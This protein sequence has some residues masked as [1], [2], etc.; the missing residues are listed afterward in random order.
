MDDGIL[1]TLQGIERLFYDMFAGLGEDLDRHIVRNHVMIH[2]V[3]E[4]F[5]FGLGSGGEAHFDFL[6]A[7]G[8]EDLVKADLFL[9]AH[10]DDQ[11]LVSV[12]QIHAAPDRCLIRRILHRPGHI[13]DGRHKISFF[14]MFDVFHSE[15]L[16]SSTFSR[17]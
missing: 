16:L 6:E 3:A 15:F 11:G 4:E 1:D 13:D 9:Q 7:N 8:Y 14:V 12:A 2:Q 5:I 17:Q 10:R